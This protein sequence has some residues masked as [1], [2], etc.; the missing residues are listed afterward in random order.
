[1]ANFE[2][3][4]QLPKTAQDEIDR[5]NAIASAKRTTAET[6]FLNA[7]L[8]YVTNRV[9]RYDTTRAF[10]PQSPNTQDSQQTDHTSTALILEAEG[11][12]L[13]DGYEG[14]KKGQF[15]MIWIKP[16]QM[17]IL[18]LVHLPLPL[19]YYKNQL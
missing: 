6:N 12:T 5:V 4:A 15:F 9:I 2:L 18:M 11:N 7:R 8:Q 17:F 14:F 3:K 13:P 10:T 19:G 1:M 16:A